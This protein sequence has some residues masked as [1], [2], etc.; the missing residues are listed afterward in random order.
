MLTWIY[1]V[2]LECVAVVR[3]PGVW[4]DT[5]SV[6]EK[7]MGLLVVPLSSQARMHTVY[8]KSSSEFG[9]KG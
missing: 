3:E 5:V 2:A 8:N 9:M 6:P 1:A 4:D 7:Q